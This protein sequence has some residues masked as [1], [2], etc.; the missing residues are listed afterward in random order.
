MLEKERLAELEKLAAR[1]QVRV[2]N[3]ELLDRALTHASYANESPDE[4][5][6]DNENLEF[7]GDSL[8]G[9][10]VSEHVF[11]TFTDYGE[12]ELSKIKALVV[13]EPTLA[14]MARELD[15]GVYLRLGKGEEASGG[16]GRS[17]LLANAFEA[18]IAAVYLDQGL[19]ACRAFV[20]G[21]LE[22]EVMQACHTGAG[23]D[24]KSRLQELVQS[25][26]KVIPSYDVIEVTGPDH[27]RRFSVEVSVLGR[28]C[29]RGVG[30]NKKT[31]EQR[32]AREALSSFCAD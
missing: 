4:S 23:R 13:S 19:P 14:Q 22:D 12:G 18:V 24:S 3:P 8:L 6:Q 29:G 15:L 21:Q 2:E 20:L 25:Q 11:S 26:H 1:M 9:M 31:A 17:S 7:L 16:R 30:R 5:T 28:V 10:I 32:A 27:D